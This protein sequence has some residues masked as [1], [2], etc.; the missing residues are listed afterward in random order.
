MM[1]SLLHDVIFEE[2]SPLLSTTCPVYISE[3][4]VMDN[5]LIKYI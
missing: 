3:H 1:V 5:I 2:N 4:N